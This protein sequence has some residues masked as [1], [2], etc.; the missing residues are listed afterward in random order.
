MFWLPVVII[1]KGYIYSFMFCACFDCHHLVDIFFS[2]LSSSHDWFILLFFKMFPFSF[3]SHHSCPRSCFCSCFLQATS[4]Y[5]LCFA[6]CMLT[7][8]AI[9]CFYQNSGNL[10][11]HTWTLCSWIISCIHASKLS[12]YLSQ[13]AIF[14]FILM[15]IYS[16][17][18]SD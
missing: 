9:R 13:V 4:E 15:E 2:D 6:A 3:I 17:F 11:W 18:L 1:S 7:S 10:L 14:H 5:S 16:H 12:Y 8:W